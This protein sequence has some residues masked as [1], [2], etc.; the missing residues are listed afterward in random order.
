MTRQV[1]ID[2]GDDQTA[3]SSADFAHGFDFEAL[4]QGA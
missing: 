1:P 4:E 3:E 2:P